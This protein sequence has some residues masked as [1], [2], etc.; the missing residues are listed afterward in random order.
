M[1]CLDVCQ[2]NRCKGKAFDKEAGAAVQRRLSLLDVHKKR[3]TP[4]LR[5]VHE[6]I[7]LLRQLD[8]GQLSAQTS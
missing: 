6:A 8:K 2:L 1:F 7:D 4:A 5:D 3:I